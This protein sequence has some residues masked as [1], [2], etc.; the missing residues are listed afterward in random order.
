MEPKRLFDDP[1]ELATA[2]E[3][4]RRERGA[5]VLA[6]G[7]FDVLH[8]GHIRYLREAAAL[9]GILVVALNDDASTRALKGA[10]RPVM[11]ER[12]RAALLLA[13]RFVDFVLLFGESTVDRALRVLRPDIHAKGTDY[14]PDT[15]P[16]RETARAIG[17]RTV[18]T[19]DPKERSSRDIIGRIRKG[20]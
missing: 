11:G 13:L 1:R 7:C 6:N 10:G 12:D 8:V 5:L 14:T 16:E 3:P 17:C 9:G 19:G 18:I 4:L 20:T 15:V 2:L